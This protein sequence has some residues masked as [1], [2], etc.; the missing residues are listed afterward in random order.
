MLEHRLRFFILKF[1]PLTFESNIGRVHEKRKAA[2]ARQ[3]SPF[4]LVPPASRPYW[5]WTYSGLGWSFNSSSG[6]ISGSPFLVSLW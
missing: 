2:V 6:V 4:D 1:I 3:P 5:Y